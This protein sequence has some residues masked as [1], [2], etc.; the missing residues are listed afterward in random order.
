M[1]IVTSKAVP[2]VSS[3]PPADETSDDSHE[4][5][6][7]RGS[8]IHP[9]NAAIIQP[10]PLTASAAPES[11]SVLMES[12]GLGQG[13]KGCASGATPPAA[14]AAL[15][16]FFSPV[17][18]G[19][20]ASTIERR[21]REILGPGALDAGGRSLDDCVGEKRACL[22]CITPRSGSAYLSSLM[23]AT[24]QLGFC[25]ESMN[26]EDIQLVVR[27]QPLRSVGDY[28]QYMIGRYSSPNGVFSMKADFFQCLPLIRNRMLRQGLEKVAF[29]YL[30]R[31][32]V[33]AQAISLFRAIRTGQW[34]SVHPAR[35]T[36][37]FNLE[38]ILEQLGCIVQM[39]A[40]WESLFA[41]LDLRPLRLTYEQLVA[42][43]EAAVRRVAAPFGVTIGPRLESPLRQQ[44]DQ[45]SAQW[46]Q[47]IRAAA[48]EFLGSLSVR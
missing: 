41:M 1:A 16:R 30:T 19:P 9:E 17:I 47:R 15:D 20:D 24:G 3:G 40:R 42:Q 12:P 25:A 39:L 29:V 36:A 26:F 37:E 8:A 6:T 48:G 27:E 21:L 31:E 18:A 2:S 38:G 34:S 5:K 43:P 45:M 13:G 46:A 14:S 23:R 28:L 4:A 7:C 33:L 10:R 11:E 22:V 32:D 35:G 44:R